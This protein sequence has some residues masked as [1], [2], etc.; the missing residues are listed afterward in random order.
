MTKD[1]KSKNTFVDQ[2]IK[3]TKT[4]RLTWTCV[5]AWSEDGE[6]EYDT[7][8][9]DIV[10]ST[11]RHGT[12]IPTYSI[13]INQRVIPASHWLAKH[14]YQEVKSHSQHLQGLQIDKDIALVED[15]LFEKQL[16]LSSHAALTG[17]NMCDSLH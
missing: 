16:R 6:N 5:H 12:F 14:L 1:S 3:A 4:G 10:I 11:C 2:L 8:C 9:N 17:R 15:F 7:T 13:K